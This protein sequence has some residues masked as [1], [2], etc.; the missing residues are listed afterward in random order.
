MTY[1]EQVY[2]LFLS[3]IDDEFFA[4]LPPQIR[5]RQMYLYLLGAIAEFK[6]CTK[7]L[8]IENYICEE[9]RVP[10]GTNEVV[11]D[12]IED[13][14]IEVIGESDNLYQEGIDYEIS[15][16]EYQ[17]NRHK[18]KFCKENIE[19]VHIHKY[20]NGNFSEDLTFEE[21]YLL[22]L[23]MVKQWIRPKRNKEENLKNAITDS[24]YKKLS[25]A[26]M[27]DKV[28]KL[29]DRISEEYEQKR[30]EYTFNDFKG[31]E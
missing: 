14:N 23:G 30:I 24:A 21:I 22:A 31:F 16:L 10:A 29:S 27:L 11:I 3:E 7:A 26:N 13:V 17:E 15:S 18:L 19:C 6:E 12:N 20:N 28:I 2:E 4:L 25:T 9:I 8:D 1:V 5:R